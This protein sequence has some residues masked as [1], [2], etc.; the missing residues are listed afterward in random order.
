MI[1]SLEKEQKLNDS[2]KKFIENL[3]KGIN[4][5]LYN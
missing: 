3:L 1:G 2:M 5:L 4:I